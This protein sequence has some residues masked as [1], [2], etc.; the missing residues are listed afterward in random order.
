MTAN[1]KKGNHFHLLF[2]NLGRR[3]TTH[4]PDARHQS[5]P[6]FSEYLEIPNRIGY[7][8]A[9]KNDPPRFVNRNR[10]N[11][12]NVYLVQPL[13][14]NSQPTLLLLSPGRK[15]PLIN[16]LPA[17]PVALLH[18]KDEILFCKSCSYAAHVTLFIRPRIGPPFEINVGKKCPVCKTGIRPDSI[19]YTCHFC[20]QILHC[21]GTAHPN[22][23]H[24]NC[25]TICRNCP[26]CL[27][28]IQQTHG[29]AYLPELFRKDV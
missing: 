8:T 27:T 9:G 1:K 15:P 3:S 6:G 16:G 5:S 23:D 21:E 24:L 2:E 20:G 11:S 7:L 28:P 12:D 4:D 17:P 22:K 18:M 25:A 13:W 26:I 14:E 10:V 19:T 29:Y